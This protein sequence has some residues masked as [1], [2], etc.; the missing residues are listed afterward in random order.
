[1]FYSLCI[2]CNT[3]CGSVLPQDNCIFK[4]MHCYLLEL[5]VV[6]IEDMQVTDDYHD[7]IKTSI[8]HR[9]NK[10]E[11]HEHQ[12]VSQP[13]NKFWSLSQICTALQQCS[14]VKSPDA[15]YF[16]F[17]KNNTFLIG[18]HL[19]SSNSILNANVTL[20]SNEYCFHLN[21]N[22][23]A[24]LFS[25]FTEQFWMLTVWGTESCQLHNIPL[26]PGAPFGENRDNYQ[27]KCLNCSS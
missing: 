17:F 3:D 2:Y 15:P 6:L 4:F 5:E 21:V 22:C 16:Q 26:Q 25:A 1:M 7:K 23:I 9:K 14:V 11:E 8:Y 13:L 10:L 18:I 27:F 20:L 19:I 24:S 12:Y